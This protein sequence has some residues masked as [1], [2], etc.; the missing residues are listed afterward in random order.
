MSAFVQ[1]DRLTPLGAQLIRQIDMHIRERQ[2]LN[3]DL[4]HYSTLVY[5]ARTLKP[6]QWVTQYPEKAQALW[7]FFMPDEQADSDATE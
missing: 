1:N 7:D 5:Q 4:R 6:T 3:N 2:P